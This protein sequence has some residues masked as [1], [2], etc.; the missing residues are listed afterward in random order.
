MKNIFLT[1]L[2]LLFISTSAFSQ[3]DIAAQGIGSN[4]A[5]TGSVSK[6][7]ILAMVAKIGNSGFDPLAVGTT[8]AIISFPQNNSY[9]YSGPTTFLSKYYSWAYI[10]TDKVLYGTQ[11]VEIPGLESDNVTFNILGVTSGLSA[12]ILL[13]V[14]RL[15]GSETS[16]ANNGSSSPILVTATPLPVTLISF[17]VKKENSMANLSWTTTA[18]SNSNRFEIQHSVNANQWSAIGTVAASGESSVNVKYAFVD[19]KP[20][21]GT[22]YYRL[23]MIDNDETFAFS[24]IKTLSF[25]QALNLTLYPNPVSDEVKLEVSDWTNVKKIQIYNLNGSVVYDAGVKVTDKINV[26]NLAS[27]VYLVNVAKLDG[28]IQTARFV[29]NR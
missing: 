20:S 22:N 14:Q 4:P 23:K 9:A 6:S 12:N 10:A 13:D 7:A 24:T 28:S 11:I 17:D 27:G 19:S 25:D 15:I 29:V 1:F 5:G 18:E 2:S 26:Q 3:A 21:A 8:E 16:L